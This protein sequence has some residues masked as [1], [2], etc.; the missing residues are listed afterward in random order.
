ME[1]DNIHKDYQCSLALW[2]FGL[3]LALLRKEKGI[4]IITLFWHYF[5]QERVGLKWIRV[6]LA[7]ELSKGFLVRNGLTSFFTWFPQA[8]PRW[9]GLFLRNTLETHW[10]FNFF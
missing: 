10:E 8:F 7:K 3:L 1:N 2:H 9:N 4:G 6:G 5:Y